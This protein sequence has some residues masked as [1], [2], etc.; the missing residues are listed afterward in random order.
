VYEP[1]ADEKDGNNYIASTSAAVSQTV[2]PAALTISASRPIVVK[3]QPIPTITCYYDG[4]R[5]GDQNTAI[6]AS[7]STTA[8]TESPVG[9]YPTTCSG[10][11]DPDYAI[12]YVNGTLTVMPAGSQ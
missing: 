6:P 8:V 4:L 10:A 7:G 1:P 12:T 5:G 3:G 9:V 11:S 2:N